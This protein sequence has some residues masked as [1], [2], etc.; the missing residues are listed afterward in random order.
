MTII[1]G[2]QTEAGTYIGCDSSL[3]AGDRQLA[4][5]Y[6]KWVLHRTWAVGFSGCWKVFNII[7]ANKSYLLTGIKTPEDFIVKLEKTLR[8]NDV[9]RH[10]DFVADYGQQL[11][12]AKR[13]GPVWHVDSVLALSEIPENVLWS[14]G[15]GADLAL[16]AGYALSNRPPEERIRI[17]IDAAK[18]YCTGCGGD[19]W[20]RKL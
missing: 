1:C 18:E 19:T 11:L 9:G 3:T 12:I 7:C 10:E 20:V 13:N 8:Q 2:L 6:Q 17:A 16:G 14:E 15:S 4:A 5:N